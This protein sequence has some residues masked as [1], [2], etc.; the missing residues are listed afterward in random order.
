MG[1]KDLLNP[2]PKKKSKTEADEQTILK[3]ESQLGGSGKVSKP[4][5]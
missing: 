5:K 3:L 4:D 1:L 2:D